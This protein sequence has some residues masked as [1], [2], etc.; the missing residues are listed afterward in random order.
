MMFFFIP[1]ITGG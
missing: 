1:E